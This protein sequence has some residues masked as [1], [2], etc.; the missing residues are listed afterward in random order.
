MRHLDETGQGLDPDMLCKV[1][2]GLL[3][4][5]MDALRK[6]ELPPGWLNVILRKARRSILRT[7]E[8]CRRHELVAA[9]AL[10]LDAIEEFD[11][12]AFARV[13]AADRRLAD[14]VRL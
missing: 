12:E 5:D 1:A 14:T 10:I 2:A 11:R 6:L 4:R 8:S 13:V 9:A 7:G 3:C